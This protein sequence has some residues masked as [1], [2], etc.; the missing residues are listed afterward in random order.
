VSDSDSSPVSSKKGGSGLT[1]AMLLL[2]VV[3]IGFIGYY[4]FI[5]TGTAKTGTAKKSRSAVASPPPPPK[6]TPL[7]R[8]Q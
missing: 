6:A 3:A 8:P 1:I 2:V 7:S 4:A 5:E